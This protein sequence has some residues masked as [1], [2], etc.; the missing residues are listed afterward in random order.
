MGFTWDWWSIIFGRIC[1][2]I[3]GGISQVEAC[4]DENVET[5]IMT[6]IKA[7]GCQYSVPFQ[8]VSYFNRFISTTSS[9]G[10]TATLIA[11]NTTNS[12]TQY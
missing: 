6:I 7:L 3:I 11:I 12:Y 8:G 9:G 5:N 4:L 1:T 2:F 10:P